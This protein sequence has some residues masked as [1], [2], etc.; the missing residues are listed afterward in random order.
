[1]TLSTWFNSWRNSWRKAIVW[2]SIDKLSIGFFDKKCF[3]IRIKI[4]N[5]LSRECTWKCHQQRKPTQR[6]SHTCTSC[7][8]HKLKSINGNINDPLACML[9]NCHNMMTQSY[10]TQLVEGFTLPFWYGC[11]DQ[12]KHTFLGIKR[13]I[14]QL[15]NTQPHKHYVKTEINITMTS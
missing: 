6:M 4:P 10:Q 7:T 2:K 11:Y 5:F 1:M 12:L 8:H 9:T 13:E 14:H 3:R 15:A